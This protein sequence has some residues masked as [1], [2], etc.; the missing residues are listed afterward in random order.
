[1]IFLFKI[2]INEYADW[3]FS[4]RAY[5][6]IWL[7]INLLKKKEKITFQ[8]LK[9]TYLSDSLQWG[10]LVNYRITE[11]VLHHCRQAISKEA[12]FYRVQWLNSLKTLFVNQSWL[13][14][15]CLIHNQ[16]GQES[17]DLNIADHWIKQ[18]IGPFW[19]ISLWTFVWPNINVKGNNHNSQT[20]LWNKK[21]YLSVSVGFI[22]LFWQANFFII[23]TS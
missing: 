13:L 16:I 14:R 11:L 22:R 2:C 8:L 7:F 4:Y 21:K 17:N 3:I 10:F 9:K 6:D 19:S 20:S 18:I 23:V 5:H 15:V 1:M 12:S